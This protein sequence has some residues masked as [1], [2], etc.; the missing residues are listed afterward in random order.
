[1]G[2]KP[3][4]IRRSRAFVEVRAEAFSELQNLH[5]PSL[6][7]AKGMGHNQSRRAGN[8]A[9]RDCERREVPP[10]LVLVRNFEPDLDR[11]VTRLVVVDDDGNLLVLRCRELG[12]LHRLASSISRVCRS[13]RRRRARNLIANSAPFERCAAKVTGAEDE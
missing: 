7:L 9:T 12:C 5:F 11:F 8:V 13:P 1:M 4:A 3:S 2:A 10:A 6:T